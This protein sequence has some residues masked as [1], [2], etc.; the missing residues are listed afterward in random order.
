LCVL[1][2][3]DL[4]GV[5]ARD[6]HHGDFAAAREMHG[7][8]GQLHTPHL[9]ELEQQELADAWRCTLGPSLASQPTIFV[10]ADP[11]PLSRAPPKE[12]ILRTWNKVRTTESWPQRGA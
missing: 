5:S 1:E 8:R 4:S 6:L 2:N 11:A 3:Q 12:N 9:T 7:A 10:L